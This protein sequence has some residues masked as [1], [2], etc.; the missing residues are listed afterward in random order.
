MP[1]I[2]DNTITMKQ[3]RGEVTPCKFCKTARLERGMMGAACSECMGHGYTAVCLNCSGTGLETADEVWGSKTKHSSTCNIC[4]GKGHLPAH[5][6]EYKGP[7]E[8]MDGSTPPAVVKP[9]QNLTISRTGVRA[10]A[11]T[12][13]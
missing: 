8:V 3:H 7:A 4:G 10:E 5:E 6:S 12:T 11:G 1:E 9:M 2:N 13:K